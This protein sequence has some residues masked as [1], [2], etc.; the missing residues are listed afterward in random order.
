MKNLIEQAVIEFIKSQPNTAEDLARFKR[1]FSKKFKLQNIS[2]VSL[3]SA[4]HKLLKTGKIKD[5]PAIR[6]LFIKRPVRSLSGIVNISVLTKP[7][8]CPGR[9]LYCP[10]QSGMPKSYLKGEPAAQ[11]AFDL[12]FDATKQVAQ[13]LEVLSQSGHAT[14]KID[15]R[16]IGATWSAYPKQYRTK[17][18][19][20]CFAACNLSKTKV[21]TLAQ[22][23]KKNEKAKHRIIG[24]AVETRPDCIDIKEIKFLRE[25]GVTKVELGVQSI[26]DNV[27]ELNKRGHLSDKTILATKLLRNAGFK[28]AYQIMPNLP[29]SNFC[30]DLEMFEILF[31]DSRFQPDFLKIYPLA[32]LKEAP[33]YKLWKNKKFKSYTLEE[34]SA[35]LAQI[36][37][38]L[39]YYVRVERVIRDIPSQYALNEAA[40]VTNLRQHILEDLKKANKACHCI[41]CREI[42]GE[43]LKENSL[44]LF[45]EKYQ[46]GEGQEFFLSFENKERTKLISLLRLRLPFG[47]AI[48]PELKDA[49]LIREVHTYG[50]QLEVSKKEKSASQHQGLGRKLLEIAEQIAKKNGYKKIAVI[51]GVGVRDYYRKFDYKLSGTYMIKEL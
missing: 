46:A 13:R 7:Y 14:D 49:A 1:E 30:K 5:N 12:K 15:L 26:F 33:L 41:R 35:L 17:F 4:Y 8:E 42:K 11:R 18:I 10:Q 51:S 29:G 20:D 32:V 37:C 19:R 36:K 21:A 24:I 6:K 34:L 28:I 43:K 47:E 9:C 16:I 50:Q 25:L 27:L 22:E 40:K 31:N 2:N 23:Q 48:L 38:S 44:E 45:I 39:P 3:L